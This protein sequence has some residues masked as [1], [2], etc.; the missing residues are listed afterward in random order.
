MH[1][2]TVRSHLKPYVIVARRRTTINHAFAAAIAPS[3]LYLAEKVQEA[4][5]VLGQ[6]PENLRCA[7][8]GDPAQTWDHIFA[9][10]KNSNFSGHGHRLGNLLPCCKA[11]NSSKGN[12]NWRSFIEQSSLPDK[13]QRIAIIDSYLAK[14]TIIELLPEDS[15]EHNRLTE[16]KAQVLALLAEADRIAKL[17]R[18]RKANSQVG[19]SDQAQTGKCDR[20]LEGKASR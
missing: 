1:Y 20:A 14:Y 9:T 12:K 3:D 8:C 17:I 10:V 6:D 7:Y 4:M 15:L 2:S 13:I 16:V 18:D 11:C 5:L 19:Q